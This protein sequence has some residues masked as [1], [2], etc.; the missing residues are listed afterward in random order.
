[1]FPVNEHCVRVK[2]IFSTFTYYVQW[3]AQLIALDRLPSS[4]FY[5]SLETTILGK[6]CLENNVDG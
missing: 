4:T 1:M 6:K 2:T 3:W 5:V